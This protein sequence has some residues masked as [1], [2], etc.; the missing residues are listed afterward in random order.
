MTTT[1]LVGALRQAATEL[2]AL[3]G[4]LSEDLLERQEAQ[5][6]TA[7]QV[8]AH[9]ADF[10]L[11]VGVRVRSVLTQD[12]PALATYDQERF[13]ERFGRLESAREAVERF[14]VN[15]LATARVLEAIDEADWERSGVHPVRGEETLRRTVE[16]LA[17][18]DRGHLEQLRQAAGR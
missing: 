9:L 7:R 15:R 10:E 14:E 1:E 18:H 16:M 17:G 11:V 4:S 5:G 8:L 3:V 12:R 13:T 2:G 6:W